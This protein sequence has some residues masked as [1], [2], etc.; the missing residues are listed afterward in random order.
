VGHFLIG[1][2]KL[3]LFVIFVTICSRS[4]SAGNQCKDIPGNFTFLA[5]W[6]ASD[7]YL[8]VHE[9]DR[10]TIDCNTNICNASV[11]LMV[12]NVNIRAASTFSKG[13]EIAGNT[14]TFVSRLD[15]DLTE[16]KCKAEIGS[17]RIES[18][19]VE[20]IVKRGKRV[21]PVELIPNVTEITLEKGNDFK[22]T[23][24][25]PGHG[26]AGISYIKWY[27]YTNGTKTE[28]LGKAV[29]VRRSKI[30]IDIEDLVIKNASIDV[31]GRYICQRGVTDGPITSAEF[32]IIFTDPKRPI[33][34]VSPSSLKLRE[35]QASSRLICSTTSGSPKPTLSW[36]KSGRKL[37]T[38]QKKMN[39][40][41]LIQ[42]PKYPESDGQ[43]ICEAKN[44]EGRHSAIASI[45]IIVPP[46]ITKTDSSHTDYVKVAESNKNAKVMCTVKRSN[47]LPKFSW[48]RLVGNEW[49]ED[50]EKISITP[51]TSTST[52]VST[53][54]VP[55]LK[56]AFFSC[57]AS[58]EAGYD[59]R[60]I[61]VLWTGEPVGLSSTSSQGKV[62]IVV[63]SCS[64][65]LIL[66][67]IIL[68]FVYN[69]RI[70]KRY[71]PYLQPDLQFEVPSFQS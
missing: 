1:K 54:V 41:L 26:T 63:I 45:Q 35:M 48:F 21:E 33:V 65:L 19:P 40:S 7:G 58:N 38:C 39:C 53:L 62:L 52:K 27:K 44:S 5:K 70:L 17:I 36:Y 29:V 6:N 18:N 13:L 49:T 22:V 9:F 15:Q 20:L 42:N 71:G 61:T 67:V 4:L 60:N 55:S 28:N 68:A 56:K 3:P 12:D 37:A 10:I 11:S 51:N 30:A 34:V 25:A 69:R 32:N 59:I 64:V 16:M 57:R 8:E 50:F 66:L 2:W 47:P 23:C 43:Y 46:A 31:E 24:Q 14:F